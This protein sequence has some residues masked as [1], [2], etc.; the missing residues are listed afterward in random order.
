MMRFI[1]SLVFIG[2]IILI[3]E[4]FNMSTLRYENNYTRQI[5]NI[6][7]GT[8]Y[9]TK[10]PLKRPSGLMTSNRVT[11]DADQQIAEMDTS[12]SVYEALE[13][14]VN[15]NKSLKETTQSLLNKANAK[16]INDPMTN[17]TDISNRYTFQ[18]LA[19]K[20]EGGGSYST[21]F[22]NSQ[23]K[24]NNPFYKVDITQMT[25]R[26]VLGFTAKDGEYLKYNNNTYNKDTS[27]VGRYQFVGKTLRDIVKRS[28]FD[29]D[30][31]FDG[32]LQDELFR[33]YMKDTLK[34]GNKTGVTMDDKIDAV[35]GRWEGFKNAS[36]EQVRKAIIDFELKE[37]GTPM[38]RS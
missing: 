9:K 3:I 21:L 24:S 29:L 8:V 28:D 14:V 32:K 26:E 17:M 30:R 33:W 16:D 20:H 18:L 23:R 10:P 19:D 11:V 31:K 27:A 35:I 34:V 37:I 7:D 38:P 1:V 12:L 15:S 2:L 6:N 36:R 4:S 22:E 5:K 25:L 13:N